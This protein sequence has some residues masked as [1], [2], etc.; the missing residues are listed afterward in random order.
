MSKSIYRNDFPL[1]ASDDVI[2]MD[3]AATSQRPQIVL[4]AMNNFYKH[5]NANP[6]R[7]VYKLSVEATQDYENARTKVAKFVG[8]AGSEEII[9][10]RN[11]SESLNLVAYSYGLN[12]IKLIIPLCLAGSFEPSILTYLFFERT[13]IAYS[14]SSLSILSIFS[15]PMLSI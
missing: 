6:L 4:D 3:N 9:F 1:L 2:Y 8:A 13:S 10:T 11:A 15:Y 14:L 12:N 7:G 5:H